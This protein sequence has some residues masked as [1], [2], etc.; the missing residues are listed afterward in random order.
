MKA[1]DLKKKKTAALD[2]WK[3]EV[4]PGLELQVM[5]FPARVK[6]QAMITQGFDPTTICAEA[7]CQGLTGKFIADL[8]EEDLPIFRKYSDD[9]IVEIGGKVIDVSGNPGSD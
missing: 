9:Q 1:E 8:T 5:E 3:K 7:A 2:K 4:L 6:I